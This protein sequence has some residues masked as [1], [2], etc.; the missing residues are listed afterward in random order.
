[1]FVRNGASWAQ[2]G[3]AL[4]A[5]NTE[6]NDR[7]GTTLALSANGSTLAIGATGEDSDGTGSGNNSAADA[8]AAYVFTRSGALW[9]QQ[10]YIKASNAQAG[11]LFGGALALTAAGN[12]LTVGAT[13]E[14][15]ASTAIN[16][17]Q[18]NNGALGA[19]AIYVF[20][21]NG[22]T[23]VQGAYIKA[24]NAEPI[25]HFGA[26]VALSADG[27]TLAVG[28]PDEDGTV[29]GA[30][31]FPIDPPPVCR[32]PIR[33]RRRRRPGSVP[34]PLRRPSKVCARHRCWIPTTYSVRRSAASP[35]RFTSS[36]ARQV[37]GPQTPTSKART[38]N[39]KIASARQ[40]R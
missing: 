26:A 10:A 33:T 22:V 34:D 31:Q 24:P 20:S 21:N 39:T 4:T 30:Q 1:V 27:N 35:A 40:W 38:T 37:S 19:G 36:C 9:T 14:D 17:D 18:A 29:T 11:D 16:G 2:Q 6:S 3:A 7:F 15:S 8:G 13:D 12:M 25:D 28:A 32:R 5:S 23:W